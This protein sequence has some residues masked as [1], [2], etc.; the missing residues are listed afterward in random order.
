MAAFNRVSNALKLLPRKAEAK[1]SWT[2]TEW[3]QQRQGWLFIASPPEFRERLRPLLSMWLDTLALRLMNQGKPGARPVWFILD[4]LQSLHALPHLQ[5]A[6]TENRRVKNPVVLGLQRHSQ[7]E[8]LYG[9]KAEAMLTQPVTKIF[10]RTDEANSAKWISQTIGEVETERLRDIRK[11]GI[12]RDMRRGARTRQLERVVDP[13]VKDSEIVSMSDLHGYV[14]SGDLVVRLSFPSIETAK[15]QEAFIERKL[16]NQPHLK[17][18]NKLPAAGGDGRKSSARPVPGQNQAR[19]LSL[20]FPS[21]RE[22]LPQQPPAAQADDDE[23]P[24]LK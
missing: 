4:D 2:A 10:L 9:S 5:A 22:Q 20:P 12:F 11:D 16:T 19:N 15:R 17:E 24:F 21:Q 3:V 7:L 13:L 6:I 23:L 8:E 18:E 14:K 1:T